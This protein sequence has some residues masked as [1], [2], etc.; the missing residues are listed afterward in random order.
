MKDVSIP[1][2]KAEPSESSVVP[3]EEMDNVERFVCSLPGAS[4]VFAL[5][6]ADRIGVVG[7][8]WKLKRGTGGNSLRLM[9]GR[10]VSVLDGLVSL[11]S[12]E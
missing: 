3:I 6:S 7:G 10:L 8:S 2:M 5:T 12:V 4:F 11:A 1:L 9:M